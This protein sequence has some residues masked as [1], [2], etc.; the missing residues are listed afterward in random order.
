MRPLTFIAFAFLALLCVS[1]AYGATVYKWTDDNGVVHY[2]SSPP[3]GEEAEQTAERVARPAKAQKETAN[4]AARP[5]WDEVHDAVVTVLAKGPRGRVKGQGSGVMI[6]PRWMVTNQHV[7]SAG[8]RLRVIGQEGR[9]WGTLVTA[10]ARADFA[11]VRLPPNDFGFL[12]LGSRPRI[13]Q[14]VFA[15]GTPSGQAGTVTMGRVQGYQD[16][17]AFEV[18]RTNARTQPGSSGGALINK[19]AE[20]V[21]VTSAIDRR[22][23]ETLAISTA[24]LV[25][26]LVDQAFLEP[27]AIPSSPHGRTAGSVNWPRLVGLLPHALPAAL[28]IFGLVFGVGRGSVGPNRPPFSFTTAFLFVWAATAIAVGATG[29]DRAVD[30]SGERSALALFVVPLVAAL[31]ALYVVGAKS[32]KQTGQGQ[33]QPGG[34]AKVGS[35]PGQGED[36]PAAKAAE[37]GTAPRVVV[38]PRSGGGFVVWDRHAGQALED[39]DDQDEAVRRAAQWS[40]ADT[41]EAGIPDSPG[42]E[43]TEV[44]DLTRPLQEKEESERQAVGAIRAASP[45]KSAAEAFEDRLKA[46][47]FLALVMGGVAA[48]IRGANQGPGPAVT[49]AVGTG[50]AAFILGFLLGPILPGVPGGKEDR[51]R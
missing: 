21:G 37:L 40:R 36:E 12:K 24:S 5:T 49:A 32:G 33:E 31:V 16:L 28:L 50:L 17:G 3:P 15:V 22:T 41:Q 19:Q 44:L 8:G 39:V 13:G 42:E 47:G 45:K 25:A 4:R 29:L 26:Y 14:Q 18:L 1:A 46:G 23:G 51:P 10:S 7:T 43:E 35:L 30:E 34:S 9:Y 11:L 48:L 2:S 27:S 38:R 6:R 20:L